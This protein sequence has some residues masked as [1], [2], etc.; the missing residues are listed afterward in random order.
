MARRLKKK[1][2]KRLTIALLII[3]LIIL[4]VVGYFTAQY[5]IAYNEELKP[6][7]KTKEYYNITDFGIEEL[8]SEKDFNEN[9]IDD[10]TDI[11]EGAKKYATFNQKYEVNYYAGGYPPIEKEGSAADLI[12]YAL[13]NAGYSLKDLVS[14]DVQK[15][16]GT[17]TY[18]I[19]DVDSNI[20]FRRIRNQETFFI[21]YAKKLD[22]DFYQI[23]EFMPG[24]IITFDNCDHIAI[25]SDKYTKDGVPYIISHRKNQ[26]QKEENILET[27]DMKITG[28]Y[29]FEYNK[30][31]QSI[32]DYKEK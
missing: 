18:Y 24:D 30:K 6:I 14:N 17:G 3:L 12:W 15:T 2:K 1:V 20:D 4:G 19:E 5:S 28:H 26:K 21:R 13:K 16:L 11:L 27:I 8:K 25:V 10:Y 32:I 22:T 7:D 31:L 29:R 9:G 23:G